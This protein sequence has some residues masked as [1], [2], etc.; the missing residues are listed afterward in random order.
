[1]L[2]LVFGLGWPSA[3]TAYEAALH[4]KF[5]FA[6]ARQLN[7][8][9]AETASPAPT[10]NALQVRLIARANAGQANTNPLIRMFRW[11]YYD[12]SGADSREILWIID[13]RFHEHFEDQLRRLEGA[14]EFGDQHRGLGRI[15]NYVQDVTSPAHVAPVNATRWW[16][17][18]L[19][20]KFDGF[21]VDEAR[22]AEAV[23]SSC[24][25]V[26][27]SQLDYRGILE[28]AAAH[29][30]AAIQAPMF[31]LPATWEAFWTLNTNPRK[32]GEY[33]PA[34]NAFGR[35]TRFRCGAGLR[36]ALL[37]EDPLYRDFALQRHLASVVASMK[38]LLAFQRSR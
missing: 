11:N 22:L 6:A 29:T 3:A 35:N 25:H 12:R 9:L 16:R 34:G 10:L 21:A 17:F 30:L 20:D 19:T 1:M 32:F 8:C 18:S 33:G 27:A 5:T 37:S 26:L 4:Q 15:V 13:T 14:D 7:I 28:E 2:A 23:A 38:V 36:C 31:G 24:D